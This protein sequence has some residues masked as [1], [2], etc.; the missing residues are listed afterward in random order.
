MVSEMIR[1]SGAAS[2]STT[3]AGAGGL[4]QQQRVPA[5]LGGHHLGHPAVGG[6]HPDTADTPVAGQA[7]LQQPVDIHRLVCA[8]KAADT[9]MHDP[10]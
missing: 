1:V 10:D 5:V 8:V 6:H 3:D 9:E 2:S 7:H 4:L